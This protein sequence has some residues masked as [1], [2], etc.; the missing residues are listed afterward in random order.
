MRAWVQACHWNGKSRLLVPRGTFS[1][2]E[3]VFQGKGNGPSAK[4]VEIKGTLKALADPSSFSSDYW[5]LFQLVDGVIV[6]GGGILD[7][8]G[9]SVWKY[10]DCKTKVN[11]ET[12]PI[13]SLLH[14]NSIAFGTILALNDLIIAITARCCRI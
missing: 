14:M 10:N 1:L 13:V 9:A 5:I 3:V 7:G 12:M 2:G 11:C 8:Q 4:V 6:I